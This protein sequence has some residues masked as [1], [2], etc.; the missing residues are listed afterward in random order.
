MNQSPE[1]SHVKRQLHFSGGLES[2]L[3]KVQAGLLDGS[4]L[5]PVQD[6]PL[7]EPQAAKSEVAIQQ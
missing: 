5:S 2:P 4:F 3:I 1:E 6:E 7:I